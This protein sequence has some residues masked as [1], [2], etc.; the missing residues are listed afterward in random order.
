[1]EYRNYMV[2]ELSNEPHD[3]LEE[4]M[5]ACFS[6]YKTAKAFAEAFLPKTDV[7]RIEIW[8][9]N[10]DPEDFTS[11]DTVYIR[12]MVTGSAIDF[13]EIGDEKAKR[14]KDIAYKLSDEEGDTPQEITAQLASLDGC[15]GIIEYL[16]EIQ[17]EILNR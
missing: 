2:M 9:T 3:G 5:I 8:G 11:R 7:D 6:D 13:D 15:Y 4:W 14:I 12:D 17:D 16:L 1:M 10:Q